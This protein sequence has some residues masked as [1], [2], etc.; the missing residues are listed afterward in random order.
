MCKCLVVS[1]DPSL[2]MSG[3]FWSIYGQCYPLQWANDLH[4]YLCVSR[5]TNGTNNEYNI[6]TTLKYSFHAIEIFSF[7]YLVRAREQPGPGRRTELYQ[8]C[9][10]V[11]YH[12]PAVTVLA[13]HHPGLSVSASSD[14]GLRPDSSKCQWRSV[15]LLQRSA[16]TL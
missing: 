12:L 4:L 11:H 3:D 7:I 1:A 2:S 8:Y 10:S 13:P 14:S 6:F 5:Y 9:L 15:Q 16:I